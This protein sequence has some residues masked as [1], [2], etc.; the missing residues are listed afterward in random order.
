MKKV[1]RIFLLCGVIVLG[2][3]L[4]KMP[5]MEVSSKSQMR[6]QKGNNT[7][8]THTTPQK[9]NN[10]TTTHTLPQKE[11]DSKQKT[12]NPS[13]MTEKPFEI[14]DDE[15]QLTKRL[16]NLHAPSPEAQ[17]ANIDGAEAKITL[18]VVDSRGMPVRGATVTGGLYPRTEEVAEIVKGQTD[19]NG[20]FSIAGK[21]RS[22]IDYVIQ[23]DGYH[24]P[25]D[26]T[27]W[28]YRSTK[29]PCFK[30]GKWIPWNPT[31]KVVLQEIQ[32]E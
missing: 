19:E 10:A 27:Y 12:T 20:M 15:L 22:F 21:T 28:V 17:Q 29:E 18:H 13:V 32:T 16:E 31:I 11:S 25:E 14:T 26:G 2:I 7:A 5:T 30:D 23:K 8:P 9:V 4:L 24:T 3:L 6:H 1:Y